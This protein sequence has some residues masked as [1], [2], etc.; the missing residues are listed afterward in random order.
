MVFVITLAG[1]GH[2]SAQFGGAGG[3]GGMGGGG[4]GGSGGAPGPSE[5]PK[6]R[7]FKHTTDTLGIGRESGDQV[8]SAVTV[9]GNKSVGQ[10]EILQKLETKSG[11]FY[12][13]ET[14]LGDVHRLNEMRVFDHVTFRTDE[15]PKGVAVTFIVHERP[16]ITEVM[17]H[18]AR[19]MNERELAGRAGLAVGDPLSEFAVES[20]RRRLIDFYKEKKFNQV[21]ITTS[22]GFGDVP[23]RVVFRINEGPLERIKSIDVI[24]NTIL[25]DARLKKIIKSREAPLG[26]VLW[27]FNSADLAQIDKD[28]D[29]LAAHYR[30]LGYLTATVG[31]Q[32]EYDKSGKYLHVTFVVNEGKR[33][34]IKNIQIVGNRFVTEDS[35]R[36]RLELKPGDMFDG[37]VLRRDVGEIVYG[38]GE[39]GFIYADVQP[40]TIMREE[41]NMVDLVYKIEE[42]DR[43]KIGE[44]RVNIE[45]EPHLMRETVMLNLLDLHEGDFIDRRLL[46]V[47]RR[48][49][50][51]GQ[52]LETNP[53]IADPPDIIVEPKEDAY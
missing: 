16:L 24:G 30:N 34:Q 27:A 52:L 22:I 12:H 21:T 17:F 19:G 2:V 43:W 3:M 4:A 29:L 32:I 48:R 15:T 53:Q 1:A 7:D 20:A 10:H 49:M 31:R 38:Y 44:I 18:G 25:S 45:G 37:T 14:L 26:V 50:T 11:R 5:R 13:R 40:Q 47:A 42:G 28:V 35:L 33:F 23:G 8:V 41:E 46:E 39:L 9:Q 6:F 36:Q 51:R